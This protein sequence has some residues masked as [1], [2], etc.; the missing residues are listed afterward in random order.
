MPIMSMTMRSCSVSAGAALS[1]PSASAA[2]AI[3]RAAAEPRRNSARL[4]AVGAAT[5]RA[6]EQ[7]IIRVRMPAVQKRMVPGVSHGMLRTIQTS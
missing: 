7:A 3:A 5:G 2:A 6:V 4:S 1:T